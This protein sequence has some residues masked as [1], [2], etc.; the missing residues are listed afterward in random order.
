MFDILHSYFA[1]ISSVICKICNHVSSNTT[2]LPPTIQFERMWQYNLMVENL[3]HADLYKRQECESPDWSFAHQFPSTTLLPQHSRF[4]RDYG[5]K[6]DDATPKTKFRQTKRKND[7]QMTVS[8]LW[9]HGKIPPN[10]L[11][12]GIRYSKMEK[13]GNPSNQIETTILV[14]NTDLLI[15]AAMDKCNIIFTKFF[16]CG[17]W[18]GGS[19]FL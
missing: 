1:C 11:P 19:R 13:F 10:I 3:L 4:W 7:G 9:I 17:F 12:L 16:P 18:R 2:Y 6:C 14:G 8:W 15:V 5:A